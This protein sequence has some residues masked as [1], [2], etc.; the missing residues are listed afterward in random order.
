MDTRCRII[1]TFLKNIFILSSL[2]EECFQVEAEVIRATI[3]FS[4]GRM[5]ARNVAS[6]YHRNKG[7][8]RDRSMPSEFEN[9]E[10]G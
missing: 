8:H 9:W 4:P 6:L 5:A 3:C 2:S 10:V 7:G 1:R